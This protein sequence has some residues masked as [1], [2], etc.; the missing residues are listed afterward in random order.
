MTSNKATVTNIGLQSGTTRT[1]FATWTWTKEN[2]DKYDVRWYYATGDGVRFIGSEQQVTI[3]NAQLQSTY[4]AP[5]NATLVKF[6]VKP[7]SKTK[8]VNNKETSYWTATWSTE[9]S[10]SFSNNPPVAPSSPPSISI[11]DFALT[12]K[13]EGLN[14]NITE[15]QFQ[16]VKNDE[17][18]FDTASILVFT[19]TASYTC[20]VDAGGTYKV[21]CRTMNANKEY[22]SWTDYS[23]SVGTVTDAPVINHY[24]AYS[25][26][27]IYL[28]WSV[29]GVANTY[30]VEYAAEK[31]YFLGKTN[32]STKVSGIESTQYLITGVT[33][34]KQYFC[35]VRAVNDQGTSGW[36]NVVP[37]TI[38]SKPG[39][40]TTWSSTTTAVVGEDVILYWVHNAEDGSRQE[41]AQVEV[42]TNGV[43]KTYTIETEDSEEETDEDVVGQYTISTSGLSQGASIRWRVRTAGI[44]EEYGDWSISREINV[45]APATLSVKITNSNG[46]NVSSITSFPFYISG[47][48]GPSSQT[49]IGFYVSIVANGYYE[50]IDEIGNV[51]VVGKGDEVYSKFYDTSNSLL[52]E[53]TAGSIDLENNIE[54]TV[55]CMVTMDTGLSA[56]ASTKF[57]VAWSD[58]TLYPNAELAFDN[59]SL[60]AYIK[61]YCESEDGVLPSGVTLSVYRRE[62]DGGFVEIGSGL[63]N[64]ENTFVTDP[65]PALDFTRYRIVARIDDTGAISYTDIVGLPT[66]EKSVVIQWDEAWSSF[67]G[68]SEDAL[69]EP[70]WS[71]S[72]IKLPYNIDVSDSSTSDVT[73]V[74]YIGRSRPVSY[75][76]TQIDSTSTWNMDIDKR[77][78]NTLYA[79]RR[80]STWMGDV[81]VR[82]PSGSGY[83]ANITVSFSQTHC[84][85]VIPVTLQIT[86]VEGGI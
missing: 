75:Y 12:T 47:T 78:K 31:E 55:N 21:R 26:S 33:S 59:D 19:G 25:E 58:E 65:H 68:V 62:F 52:L 30:E 80:L 42:T 23:T 73:L 84:E 81:Y 66:W 45:Y 18:V 53:L 50:T 61:P 22:S 20:N 14:S 85:V 43:T 54:Y 71:G 1:V 2:T 72:M 27:S 3:T 36:S 32:A 86:R 57:K 5:E 17:S 9:V 64:T 83:W 46:Q 41:Y 16:I 40:P 51:K 10:Y 8:T 6:Q 60:C 4:T 28:S 63:I 79:L 35:R 34:G 48:A 69:E 49:P 39:A 67:D 11:K 7:I 74:K 15:V 37:V 70:S 24:R 44:T 29:T 38:G 56:E 13:V 82:E 76:G 77:D